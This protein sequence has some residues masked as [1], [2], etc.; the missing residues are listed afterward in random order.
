M[1]ADFDD[2]LAANA[3]HVKGFSGEGVR[4]V[5]GRGL[6]VLTCM[7]SRI[8]PHAALGLGAG[9]V[10]VIH[11]AG[12][13]LNPEVEQDIILASHLLEVERILI[14]PHTRCAMASA[15][16]EDVLDAV[17]F[18]SGADTTAFSPRLIS[19]VEAKLA[20]DVEALRAN[21]LLRPGVAVQGAFY[22]VDTGALMLR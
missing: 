5:A 19:D 22:D 11:N 9:E 14:M 17:A 6:L 15:T 21:P 8:V 18:Q 1:A 3:A 20:A 16:L 4:G 2:I 7:D 10:K 13:Q 12:G